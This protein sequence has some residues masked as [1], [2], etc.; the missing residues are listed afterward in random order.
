MQKEFDKWN[1]KK[2][3][4][5][6]KTSKKLF[7]EWDIWWCSLWVNIKSESYWKWEDFRRPVLVLKKLSSDTCIVLPLSSQIKEWSWFANYDLHW[8]NYTAL[9]YQIKMIHINRLQRRLWELDET[10]FI[11]IKKRLKN[12]LNL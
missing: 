5:H 1:E 7:K 8:K 9:L 2:K 3:E 4:I 6:K 12:L 10:D 11:N